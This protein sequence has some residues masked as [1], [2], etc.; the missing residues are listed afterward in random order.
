MSSIPEYSTR[1]GSTP[2]DSGVTSSLDL[3]GRGFKLRVYKN[4]IKQ[5][6]ANSFRVKHFDFNVELSNPDIKSFW[7]QAPTKIKKDLLKSYEY[8]KS[9]KKQTLNVETVNWSKLDFFKDTISSL[10]DHPSY[11]SF[12][13]LTGAH[14]K[15]L[16]FAN[17]HL[18]V[19]R[20][21]EKYIYQ[22]HWDEYYPLKIIEMLKHHLSLRNNIFR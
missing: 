13:R 18:C 7:N 15:N 20:L 10:S 12:I 22:V 6:S 16:R 5:L 3:Y 21:G 14:L 1:F 11:S 4:I 9:G 17:I 19:D 8:C 2:A